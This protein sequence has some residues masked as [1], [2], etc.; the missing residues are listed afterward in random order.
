MAYRLGTFVIAALTWST[1]A[2]QTNRTRNAA[3]DWPMYNRDL[4]GTRFSP[5]VQINTKNVSRLT[6][7]WTYN[8][9]KV[10]AEGITC[11]T[12]MTPIVVNGMMYLATHNRLVALE[13]YCEASAK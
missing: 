8:V 13:R 3:A 9:G 6:R 2:V 1:L 12:E 10:K 7:A 4:A 11:G 5:L